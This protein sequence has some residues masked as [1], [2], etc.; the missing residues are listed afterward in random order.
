VSDALD[1]DE[2]EE[3]YFDVAAGLL[4][5][6]VGRGETLA[7]AESLTGGM[8]A[9]E[10][11]AAPGSSRAFRGS[12]TA[13]ATDLKRELL[14]VD[15]ALLEERGA[16]DEDVARAMAEGV[17]T[18]L[19][20]SWGLSTTGV[21]GPEPQDGRP[22]GTVYTAVAGPHGETV[23]RELSLKGSRAEIRKQSAES[24]MELLH[25]ELAGNERRKDKEQDGG[26]GCLQP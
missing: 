14:G 15:G 19:S 4:E 13:Y 23:C 25:G 5:L 22:V 21:A 18:A 7:V 20:A 1:P 3:D 24:A 12:V 26:N 2:R 6:L 16:V 17:R 9:A 10:I 11:T 8:V